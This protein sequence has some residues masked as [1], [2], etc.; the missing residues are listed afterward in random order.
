MLLKSTLTSLP[1]YFMYLFVIFELVIMRLEKTR[2][3]FLWGG[4]VLKKKFHLV[5]W[6]AI[7]KDKRKGAY[8]YELSILYNILLGEMVLEVHMLWRKVIVIRFRK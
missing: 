7:Y 5:K 2:K 4:G 3:D 1:V 8:S 6:S